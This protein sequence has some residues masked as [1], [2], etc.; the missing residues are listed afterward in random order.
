MGVPKFFSYLFHNFDNIILKHLDKDIEILYF[1]FNCLIH[2]ICNSVIS[3]GINSNIQKTMFKRIIDYTFRIID[4]IKPKSVYIA[5]DGICPMAKIVQQRKRRYRSIIDNQLRDEIK[6]KYN[7]P[8]NENWSN[9]VI[10]V[11]TVFMEDLHIFLTKSF[12]KLSI[13][14]IYSSYHTPNEGEHKI[15]HHIK[16]NILQLKNKNIMIYGLDADLIFLSMTLDDL[17]VYLLR[18]GEQIKVEDEFIYVDINKIKEHI[19]EYI[20]KQTKSKIELKRVIDDFIFYCIFLGNDFL[21]TLPLISIDNKGVEFLME[22]YIDVVKTTHTYLINAKKSRINKVFL[23]EFLVI[24]NENEKYVKEKDKKCWETDSYKKEIWNLDNLKVFKI[25]DVI[26]FYEKNYRQRYNKYFFTDHLINVC[27]NYLEGLYFIM[28]YYFNSKC[29]WTWFYKYNVAPFPFD[30]LNFYDKLIELTKIEHNELP[31]TIFEQLL[32]TIPPK[33]KELLP[34][35][36]QSIIDNNESLF[37]KKYDLEM[38]NKKYFYECDPK[39]KIIN[40]DTIKKLTKNI[41]F[42][43]KEQIRN[44]IL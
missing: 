7:K 41:T 33:Q 10:S 43:S 21:P 29:N 13:N 26:K 20:K 4:I 35:N 25:E 5:V 39:I 2:P 23:H 16:E 14:Y 31:Y 1:D 44:L 37:P 36:Y 11:G 22:V 12:K 17:N 6:K 38:V 8:Y 40:I 34:K 32:L 3:D 24:I 27:R 15:I 30:I 42:S 18:E 19:Y 28:N 9:N